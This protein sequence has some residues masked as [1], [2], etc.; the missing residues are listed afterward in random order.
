MSRSNV[1]YSVLNESPSSFFPF[2]PNISGESRSSRPATP[3]LVPTVCPGPALVFVIDPASSRSRTLTLT[4]TPSTVPTATPTPSKLPK[5]GDPGGTWEYTLVLMT[6]PPIEPAFV[7]PPR[8][9]ALRM[10]GAP[11]TKPMRL[12]VPRAPNAVGVGVVVL[13]RGSER[14]DEGPGVP[15]RKRRS[16]ARRASYARRST[17]QIRSKRSANPI[18]APNV[19]ASATAV[20]EDFDEDVAEAEAEAEADGLRRTGGRLS[21]SVGKPYTR[22]E[23]TYDVGCT[24]AVKPPPPPPKIDMWG[25]DGT[26]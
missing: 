26:L 3:G 22:E 20:R 12:G 24:E 17:Y 23:G 1:G 25:P 9:S 7:C 16:R 4:A 10:P 19:A 6:V 14:V 13:R 5:P 21:V 15:Y 18:S 2:F 11:V 8:R